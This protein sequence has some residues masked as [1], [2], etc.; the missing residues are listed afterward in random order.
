MN[1]S[2]STSWFA[3]FNN[4]EEH[5][6]TGTPEEICNK[7]RDE[8]IVD[9]STRSGAWAYCIS[10][11]GLHHVHMVLEDLKPMR[12]SAIKKE[13][14]KGM[15]FE[16]TKGSKR[17]AEAYINKEGKFAEKGETVEF[18][19]YH[20]EIKGKQGKRSDLVDYYERLEAGETVRD[21]LR[22]TP[23]AYCHINVL[24]NMYFDI[25]SDKTPIVRDMRVF[26]HTGPSGSGK[27]YERVLLSKDIGE[28]NIYY[29][30]SFNAGSFDRY[31]G[32]PVL[33]IEDF[34][35][36]FK[37]QELLRMLDKYKAE[38]PARYCN[39]KAL[40]NEVHI[41]SV[42]TP[43]ECYSKSTLDDNDRIDQLLRRISSIC[44]HYKT[45]YGDFCKLHFPSNLLRIQMEDEVCKARK[46]MEEF[47]PILSMEDQESVGDSPEGE[48]LRSEEDNNATK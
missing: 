13:Y 42:L 21:I 20:G 25:R 47:V 48:T 24:K 28:E 18:I 19:V 22:D 32:E 23:K 35:G 7:L 46:F 6:Y 16:A 44:Y 14:C 10:E 29:L 27:S 5:G 45:I 34:R 40:W 1:D 37:L 17:Q 41:T 15:H 4:P 12:F 36:E 8:W 9:N 33:W 43:Q 3:V 31:N 39:V 38:I 26:W 11:A 2:V 30:T